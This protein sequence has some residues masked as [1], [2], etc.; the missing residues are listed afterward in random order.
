MLSFGQ[1]AYFV[2]R[3]ELWGIF[4]ARFNPEY[5]NVFFGSGVFSLQNNMEKLIY[6][7]INMQQIL[8]WDFCSHTLN[9]IDFLV[10]RINWAIFVFVFHY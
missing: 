1:V 2:N 9:I 8:K 4:L 6:Q 10:Y 3:S 7:N 5:L